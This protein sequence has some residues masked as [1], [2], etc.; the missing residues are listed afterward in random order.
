MKTPESVSDRRRAAGALELTQ[1]QTQPGS[2]LPKNEFPLQGFPITPPCVSPDLRDPERVQ[3]KQEDGGS[4]RD[5]P[6]KHQEDDNDC[7]NN[8][9]EVGMSTKIGTYDA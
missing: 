4:L 8:P 7:G 2:T 5:D 1:W 9:A 6:G 3:R